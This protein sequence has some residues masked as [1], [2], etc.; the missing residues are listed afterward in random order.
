MPMGLCLPT[1]AAAVLLQM[2]HT[3]TR[4]LHAYHM[5]RTKNTAA[6]FVA[7]TISGRCYYDTGQSN[8][9]G[10][11]N[12]S[13]VY[14]HDTH[15]HAGHIIRTCFTNIHICSLFA[16]AMSVGVKVR[17]ALHG[18]TMLNLQSKC[19]YLCL[20]VVCDHIVRFFL[21]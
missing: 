7:Y 16:L 20:L 5:I 6:P 17:L 8:C 11:T 3:I 15:R 19:I 21:L 18:Q 2:H 14:Y 1:T 9:M 4:E 12:P 10:R 13:C